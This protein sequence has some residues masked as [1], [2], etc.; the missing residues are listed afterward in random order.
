MLVE[1]RTEVRWFL[2]HG[3]VRFTGLHL[4]Q[5]HF[6]DSVCDGTI[7]LPRGRTV[8]RRGSSLQLR[9]RFSARAAV[10]EAATVSDDELH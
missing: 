9:G 5:E 3:H 6:E 8:V 10:L 7:L 1:E 4:Q 2:D